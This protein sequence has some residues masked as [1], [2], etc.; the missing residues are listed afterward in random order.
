MNKRF[1][2]APLSLLVMTSCQSQQLKETIADQDR[3]LELAYQDRRKTMA[4]RDRYRTETSDLRDRLQNEQQQS[5]QLRQRLSAM[6]ASM[7]NM[8][9]PDQEVENLRGRL[10]GSD[11]GVARRGDVIVLDLPS[12][13]TFPSGSA[14][15]NSKGRSSLKAVSDILKSDYTGKTFWVEGHTDDDPI[16]KSKWKTNLRLSVERAMAVSAYLT[17]DLGIEETQVRVSGYGEFS[18]K[19]PN[20]SKENKATNRRVEILILD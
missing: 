6:E 16:R 14:T 19:V 5:Y 20:D 15:L 7:A 18:P 4:D 3:Q 8:Q 12:A 9:S 11:V 1:L 2:I 10:R 17:G 13:L